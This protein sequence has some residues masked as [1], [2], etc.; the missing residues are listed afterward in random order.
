MKKRII[1]I[2]AVFLTGSAVFNS[3][4]IVPVPADSLLQLELAEDFAL[5]EKNRIQTG[6]LLDYGV[7]Y[8]NLNR[9]NGVN[10]DDSSHVNMATM[11]LILKS[12][13]NMAVGTKPFNPVNDILNQMSMT[14]NS[15][16][17]PV[18]IVLYEYNSI[19]PTAL[20]NNLISYSEQ[21]G[22]QD[23][24]V[25]GEWQDP[26]EFKTIAA[27]SPYMNVTRN[28][29][30]VFSF[31]SAYRFTDK[32][33]NSISFNPGD[34]NGFR[35]VSNGGNVTATYSSSGAKEM[36][37]IITYGGNKSVEL[38]SDI[39]VDSQQQPIPPTFA[40][41][42]TQTFTAST[43]YMG[44][45][46]SAT[47]SI[48]Y[49]SN[50]TSGSI[51]K[52]VIVVEGFDP[53]SYMMR[54]TTTSIIGKGSTNIEGYYNAINVNNSTLTSYYDIIYVDWGS[55]A[56]PIQANADILKQIIIWVNTN[57]ATDAT[58]NILIGQSM[59]GLI[60][61]YALCSMENL[62]IPHDV[63]IYVSHDTPHL[64]VNVPIG[65]LYAF[66][67]L[68][69]QLNNLLRS[70]FVDFLVTVF[71][72]TWNQADTT[73]DEVLELNMAPSVRQ[74]LI[75]Y[76]NP[77]YVLDNTLFNSFQAEL[78]QMGFPQGDSGKTIMNL[79][80]SNG[81]LIE[82]PGE[83]L[84]LF[85]GVVS[86]DVN[87]KTLFT[88]LIPGFQ[89]ILNITD[90]LFW[91]LLPGSSNVHINAQ[92]FPYASNNT[93]VFS[94]QAFLQKSGFLNPVPHLLCSHVHYSPTTGIPLDTVNGS[95]Y[96][97]KHSAAS[98]SFPS[99]GGCYYMLSCAD[100]FMFVPTVSSLCYGNGTA[101]LTLN[102]YN[103]N[104]YEEGLDLNQIPFDGY[105]FAES[106]STYHTN[107]DRA[108]LL[109][110][111]E[112]SD[113]CLSGPST[114]TEGSTFSVNGYSNVSWATSNSQIATINNGVLHAVGFG[115]FDVIATV[116]MTNGKVQL[117]KTVT[118]PSP[119]FP[120]FPTYVLNK[121]DMTLPEIIQ[122]YYP[123]YI[124][125]Q[126]QG[127]MG[128]EF[129]SLFTYYWGE[130]IGSNPITWTTSSSMS[131]TTSVTTG[132]VKTVYF[133]AYYNGQYSTTYSTTI[134]RMDLVVP[135]GMDG[136]G[137]MH[138]DDGEEDDPIHVKGEVGDYVYTY[139]IDS[140]TF[141]FDH[142]ASARELCQ[143]MLGC[144]DLVAQI[145]TL[146]PWGE[147]ELLAIDFTRTDLTTEEVLAG[148]ILIMYQDIGPE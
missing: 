140:H 124:T 11:E 40:V 133:K 77:N 119:T 49:A 131:Y 29:T 117:R 144:E 33:I 38:K 48:K 26:Y 20:T 59:G 101:Q 61:R 28:Q 107:Y 68:Y 102:D 64:G 71:S 118:I 137:N 37:L 136:D 57:K 148:I 10:V 34:G 128:S 111:E 116:E 135:M 21:T 51:K 72:L 83:T 46:P 109:W 127:S 143:V 97:L 56:A 14:F 98:Y 82:S 16:T 134:R 80:I 9:F 23:V 120:G 87:I 43:S 3:K 142:E 114:A 138:F 67:H 121:M 84:A 113:L 146:R 42:A 60:S 27:F 78:N 147:E 110:A 63:S 1:T 103:R 126:P 99:F 139:Q 19:T 90:F 130:K 145:K 122:D 91:G 88:L 13:R 31:N 75:N 18:G 89:S 53:F 17:N 62:G 52:P 94:S 41:D 123:F 30:V 39:L 24:Y 45:Q 106:Y 22:F 100:K 50:N 92:V 8:V 4:A 44:Y 95:Y 66:Q 96:R 70:H 81:G 129:Y 35:S 74:M 54:D 125:A 69:D 15:G 32:T 12:L 65:G 132:Q 93:V 2:V 85:N 108:V 58:S 6:L 112:C 105:R 79:T 104:F 7:D 73:I 36:T 47:I 55:S 25:A 76:V 115:T 86:A 141:W 5:L